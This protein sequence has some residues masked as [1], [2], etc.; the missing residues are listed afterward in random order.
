MKMGGNSA[1]LASLKILSGKASAMNENR[2]LFGKFVNQAFGSDELWPYTAKYAWLSNQMAHTMM[3]F[4]LA[5][6]VLLLV[7]SPRLS[8]PSPSTD[9]WLKMSARSIWDSLPTIPRDAYVIALFGL[10]PL[11]EIV[12]MLMDRLSCSSSPIRP[13]LW[14]LIFD[15]ITDISFWWTGMFLAALII[16]LFVE[17]W[18]RAIIPLVGLGVCVPFWCFY[19][20][21]L[22][23]N[24]KETFDRS[25]MP[26][27]YTR[28]SRLAESESKNEVLRKRPYFH[29]CSE[30]KWAELKTFRD[31]IIESDRPPQHHFL[32]I[33]GLPRDRTNLAVALG[34]EFAFKLGREVK[35]AENADLTRVYYASAPA[36]LE[37]PAE[38]KG[39]VN[40]AVVE[41]VIVNHLD[42][43]MVLPTKV[44]RKAVN[45]AIT[46]DDT[47]ERI[48]EM[49]ENRK[50]FEIQQ[51]TA[52]EQAGIAKPGKSVISRDTQ[53]IQHESE[54]RRV[55]LEILGDIVKSHD[56]STIW[57]LS[58]NRQSSSWNDDRQRWIEDIKNLVADEDAELRVIEL[59]DT[60]SEKPPQPAPNANG[61]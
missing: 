19:A 1:A 15:S 45:E 32:I 61:R 11:K 44:S 41:C 39:V 52:G 59:A 2:S 57:V 60:K 42:S 6:V 56:I 13:N 7:V 8:Q 35:N 3:G 50:H 22:W 43:A 10:I 24:Q 29:D 46:N 37:H 23:L 14:P 25:G 12:D 17:G 53:R 9:A 20:A 16:G 51:E 18:A 34:S 47:R 38:L 48:V 4:A 5:V 54:I 30:I 40:P 33:G 26:F 58:G 55:K 31:Q 28:L 49:L 27:A 36:I 21:P